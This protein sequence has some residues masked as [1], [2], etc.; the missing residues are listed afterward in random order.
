[1]D[2]AREVARLHLKSSAR[3]KWLAAHELSPTVLASM[4]DWRHANL[5]GLARR[6]P[7]DRAA[8]EACVLALLYRDPKE[9]GMDRVRKL[10][11]RVM[12][13]D[14]KRP[15]Q[16]R[17]HVARDWAIVQAIRA[18]AAAAANMKGNLNIALDAVAD[19]LGELGVLD[20]RGRAFTTD[21]LL[22]IWKRR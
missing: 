7:T 13:G 8:W 6:A 3:N 18:A 4:A 2:R 5:E 22:A 17:K 20:S 10:A 15:P 1:M 11:T 12:N 19:V 16:K 21:T 14:I 9:L